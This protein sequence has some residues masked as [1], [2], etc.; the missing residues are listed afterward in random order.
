MSDPLLA[1][2]EYLDEIFDHHGYEIIEPDDYERAGIVGGPPYLEEETDPTSE[3]YA[4]KQRT[5][6][7]Q[8]EV[9]NLPMRYAEVLKLRYGMSGREMS[10]QEVADALG[11]SQPMVHKME[12]E[13]INLLRKS[14]AIRSLAA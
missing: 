10:Q 13:A 14:A 2:K 11:V 12:K 3:A 9:A 8:K 7:V 6:L 1:E 5:A 4:R